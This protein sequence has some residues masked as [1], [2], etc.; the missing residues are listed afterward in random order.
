MRRQTTYTP[1]RD[2]EEHQR[3]LRREQT[4]LYS[5]ILRIII[6]L[7]TGFIGLKEICSS[8]TTNQDVLL[9]MTAIS[10]QFDW[11][12]WRPTSAYTPVSTRDPNTPA[13]LCLP[14]PDT[15]I[16]QFGQPEEEFSSYI[17]ED[18]IHAWTFHANPD[19]RFGV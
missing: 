17:S 14:D 5:R 1:E 12:S 19:D 6:A 9:T 3:E 10:D 16:T 4:R 18:Q 8:S 13:T 11:E 15:P 2:Y 7:I